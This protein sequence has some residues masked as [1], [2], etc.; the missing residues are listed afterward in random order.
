MSFTIKSTSFNDGEGIP[1]KYTCDGKSISPPLEWEGFPSGTKSFVLILDDPDAVLCTW[2][3]WIIYNIPNNVTNLIENI[4]ALS[5]PAKS[6]LNSWH[7]ESYIAPCPIKGEHRYFFKLFALN[8]LLEE[9]EGISRINIEKLISPYI[10][11]EAVL[12]GKYER[13]KLKVKQ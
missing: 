10:I 12:M 5:H 11:G 3:H 7:K 1:L 9:Q 8:T 13:K 2:N 6:G 4:H